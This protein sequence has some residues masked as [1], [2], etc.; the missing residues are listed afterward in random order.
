MTIKKKNS[1]YELFI[2]IAACMW[3]TIGLFNRNMV[4]SGFAAAQISFC[5]AF[6]TAIIL[7]TVILI[8]D[9][10]LF[11]IQ[12]RHIP[13]FAGTGIVSFLFFNI[14]Y[15]TSINEN[16]LSVAAMLLYTSPVFVTLISAV[17]FKEKITWIKAAALFLALSGCAL[18]TFEKGATV[19]GFGLIIGLCSGLGYALY[20][21]F[22]KI[23]SQH[24]NTLTVTFYTFVFATLGGIPICGVFQMPLAT[25]GFKEYALIIGMAL[26]NTFL[27]YVFY[28]AGL[29]KVPAG[30]ASVISIIEPVVA[31]VCGLFFGEIIGLQ[32]IIGIAFVLF[33][34]ILL[35]KGK[36]S[37]V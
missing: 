11:K 23:A 8:K 29:K 19:T 37:K 10:S 5:R 26:L 17:V 7:G 21:I 27:P 15:M 9:R 22:G 30:R 4:S 35:E 20:S 12:L 14:C 28:T 3:G 24:Y 1:I 16:S 32:G 25:A 36:L 6:I 13:M 2:I 18:L 33:A 34:I 31:T